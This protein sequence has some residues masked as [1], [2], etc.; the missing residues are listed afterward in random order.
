M[1]ISLLNIDPQASLILG[2]LVVATIKFVDELFKKDFI[3]ATKIV[4]AG[5]VGALVGLGIDGLTV[6]AG[7]TYGLAASG[8]ITAVSL[9]GVSSAPGAVNNEV[10]KSE[11]G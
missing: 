11:I 2:L 7:I 8:L 3:G 1:D 5:I 9:V 10:P 4:A 6:L